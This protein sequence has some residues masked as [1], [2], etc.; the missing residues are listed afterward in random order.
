MEK[1]AEPQEEDDC[2][3]I[4]ELSSKISAISVELNMF[5]NKLA[6]INPKPRMIGEIEYWKTIAQEIEPMKLKLNTDP[7]KKLISIAEELSNKIQRAAEI[8]KE[9]LSPEMNRVE[10]TKDDQRLVTTFTQFT[11]QRNRLMKGYKE[12]KW[13][14]KYMKLISKPIYTIEENED[15]ST[16][17]CSISPLMNSL[18][19]IYEISNF[20]KEARIISFLD[21]LF[22]ELMEKIR[23]KLPLDAVTL[24]MLKY[25]DIEEDIEESLTILEKYKKGFFLDTMMENNQSSVDTFD[26][27]NFI[28]PDTRYGKKWY[29]QPTQESSFG[30][31]SK[32]GKLEPI[33]EVSP[34]ASKMINPREKMR[35]DL[36]ANSG[37][38]K[39]EMPKSSS[40]CHFWFDRAKTILDEV[41]QSIDTIQKIKEVLIAQDY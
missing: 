18:K 1:I 31:T 39:T 41:D 5:M 11:K 14:D 34:S 27:L 36:K 13:N 19:S 8:M 24:K 33:L 40:K 26:F 23:A 21:H 2:M 6:K 28:R 29:D 7:D 35:Q 20:Y 30:G 15:L 16:I 10:I 9:N 25:S 22:K 32:R 3:T 4:L 17:Q 37:G 38:L 12:A